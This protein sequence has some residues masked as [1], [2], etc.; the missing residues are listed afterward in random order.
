MDTFILFI[1]ALIVYCVILALF[2]MQSKPKMGIWFGLAWPAAAIKDER[3]TKLQAEY[4]KRY[5][6]YAIAAFATM[7]PL[8]WL[9]SSFSLALIYF[10]LWIACVIS[11]ST[12]PFKQI[13]HKATKLKRDNGWFVGGRKLVQIE[14]EIER[15][16]RMRPLSPYWFVIPAM[17]C[18]PL[19][20][21][22]I[23][24]D[25]PLLR[26]TGVA[27]LVM[28]GV[29]LLIS[30]TF[31]HG[32]QRAYSR[33]AAPNLAIHHAARRYWSLFWL[34]LAVFEVINAYVAYQVLFQGTSVSPG[35]WMGGIVMVSL[36]PLLGIYFVNSRI[37]DLEY[38]YADTDGVSYYAD[39]DIYWRHGL[40]YYNPQN[41][42]VIV[43]KRVGIGTTVNLATTGGK[44]IQYGSVLLA[45]IIL[46]PIM[47]MTIRADSTPPQLRIEDNGT[48]A[49]DDSSY[50][51]SFQLAD[52]E[53]LTLEDFVPSGFRANGMATSSYARGN[54]KLAELGAAK[55]Y[56][57]K[58][59][60]PFIHIKLKDRYIVYNDEEAERTKEL[61]RE[62]RAKM[63]D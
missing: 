40:T 2:L 27:S 17:M 38:L 16:A 48:V 43:P 6:I 23:Q 32:K 8:L 24:N 4:R 14:T 45:A 51:F 56:V 54:F 37:K 60:P 1:P 57:F 3:L 36:V 25:S 30:L 33:N 26:M 11:T 41:K 19:I 22:S 10:F 21:L 18:L 63:G 46:I 44:L 7:L 58:R 59:K 61:F 49:I 62:L 50:P 20:V 53:E 15:Y 9:G 12:A 42:S 13:H 29:T 28:T 39:Q 31:T 35:L 55:L 34:G 47:V 5:A 52:I